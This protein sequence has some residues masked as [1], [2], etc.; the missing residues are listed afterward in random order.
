MASVVYN[1][2]KKNTLIGVNLLQDD[3]KCILVDDTYTPDIDNHAN[4]S[5]VTGEVVG[6]GYS[7]SGVSLTGKTLSADNDNDKA[8]FSA[9]DV[10]WLSTTITARGAVIYKHD[11]TPETSCLVAYI[12]FG[13]NRSSQ[14]GDF[15]LT[16]SASDGILN[17]Q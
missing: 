10:I 16:W 7:T 3:V 17:I 12:D 2:F 9:D 11:N 4:Y 6:I 8:I 13:S 5:D 1:N 15:S 14:A